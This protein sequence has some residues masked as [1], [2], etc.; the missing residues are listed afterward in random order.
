MSTPRG[1]VTIVASHLSPTFG[2]EKCVL[3]LHSKLT[4]TSRIVALGGGAAELALGHEVL[5]GPL[6]GWRRVVSPLRLRRWHRLRETQG[7][8]GPVILAGIWV[9][10]PFLMVVRR[11]KYPVVIWD[12]SLSAEKVASSRGLRVLQAF[13][14]CL[15]KKA[16]AVVVVSDDLR[17]SVASWVAPCPL[18][19]IPNF[20]DVSGPAAPSRERGAAHGRSGQLRL[21]TVGSLTETKNH[22]LALEAM[23]SLPGATLTVVGDGKL[24]HRLQDLAMELGVADR[25][26]WAGYVDDTSPYYMAS[27]VVVHP[28]LGETFGLVMFEAAHFS[29]PVVAVDYPHARTVIPTYVVGRL[30][31]PRPRQ[32]AE[33]IRALALSPPTAN[34]FDI[35]AA[36]RRH[37][38]D[39]DA[40]VLAWSRVLNA[41]EEA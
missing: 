3:N 25:I 39:D 38:Y 22:A 21:L 40:I 36:R 30:A 5:G 2:L 10:V 9:A 24:L 23:Q 20:L 13:A 19:A 27:D 7:E 28:A 8:H 34:E 26:V 37:R 11:P 32:F 16:S 18:I 41:V 15:Y 6:V 12:H 1:Q 33:A 31:S 4:R 35:A 17:D 29:V 14:K